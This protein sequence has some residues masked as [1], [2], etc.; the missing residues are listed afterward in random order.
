MDGDSNVTAIEGGVFIRGLAVI[1]GLTCDNTNS[2]A[3][4]NLPSETVASLAAIKQ[5][6]RSKGSPRDIVKS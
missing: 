5:Q 4:F 1:T 2:D 6:A 3:A